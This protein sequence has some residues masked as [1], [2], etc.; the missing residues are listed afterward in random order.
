MQKAC[1]LQT[2]LHAQRARRKG[3]EAFAAGP[4]GFG[5][6]LLV[7]AWMF[8]EAAGRAMPCAVALPE[9]SVHGRGMPSFHPPR[10][11][12]AGDLRRIEAH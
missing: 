4:V 11:E 7:V 5:T 10:A 6:W 12:G 9:A 3:I 1:L 8:D 2:R